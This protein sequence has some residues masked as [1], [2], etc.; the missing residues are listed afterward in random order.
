[1]DECG[2]C[3]GSGIPDG[4]CDCDSDADIYYWEMTG[5]CDCEGNFLDEC[6][7]CGGLGMQKSDFVLQ[8]IFQEFYDKMAEPKRIDFGSGTAVT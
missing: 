8:T 1:M 7:V 4:A 3:G 2:V 6:G 5:Q